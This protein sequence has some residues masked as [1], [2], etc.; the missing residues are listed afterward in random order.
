MT[1]ENTPKTASNPV[2][3]GDYSPWRFCTAPMME[4]SDAHCRYFW[5]LLSK[6]ARLYTEMVTS[7]ALIHGDRRRFLHFNQEEHPIALQ[8]GGSHIAELTECAKIA[9]DAGFDEINLNC[10][11]PSDRVQNNKIGACLMAEP[12]LVAECLNTMQNAVNIPVTVK[13]R[14]GIDDLDSEEYLHTFVAEL[15]AAGC[16]V[17]IVHARKAWLNGLSPKENREVPPLHYNYVHTL[18]KA[19]KDR[20]FVIN[21]G[22][23]TLAQ[24]QEQLNYVDGVMMGREAYHNPFVMAEVDNQL[25]NGNSAHSREDILQAF[26]EYSWRQYHSGTRLHHM[27]RHVLGIFA[28]Q[29]GGK[30]FRRFI[31]E[32]ACKKD[33][34][35]AVLQSALDQMIAHRQQQHAHALQAGET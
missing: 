34:T 10:G 3:T 22:I 20:T 18:K 15:A 35:P 28:G 33:A 11:C 17:F 31:S 9:E 19:F 27:S 26:I 14:T 6:N 12:K 25:F 13:H 1:L 7:G 5:R 29:H 16:Q 2:T 21:G 4:W 8:L 30:L 23:T 24:S 32:N